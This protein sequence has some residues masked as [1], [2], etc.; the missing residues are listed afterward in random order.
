MEPAERTRS[1]Y[2]GRDYSSYYQV[3]DPVDGVIASGFQNWHYFTQYAEIK[4]WVHKVYNPVTKTWN[5]SA[6]DHKK[7]RVTTYSD[8]VSFHD[9]FGRFIHLEGRKPYQFNPDHLFSILGDVPDTTVYNISNLAWNLFHT[10]VKN[11]VSIVNFIWELKDFKELIPNLS[12]ARRNPKKFLKAAKEGGKVKAVN[13]TFLQY[14]FNWAPFIGDLQKMTQTVD[15]ISKRLDFLRKT[16]NKPVRLHYGNKDIWKNPNIGVDNRV[17]PWAHEYVGYYLNGYQA[18]YHASCI[19]IQDLDGLDDAWSNWKAGL[20]SL[21]VT[22]PLKIVWNAIPFSFLLDWVW[23]VSNWLDR[24]A[25]QPFTGRWDVMDVTYSL[26]EYAV[27]D[28]IQENYFD[29]GLNPKTKLARVNLERY[30]RRVG[31]PALLPFIDFSNLTPMEQALFG[32]LI[33][34]RHT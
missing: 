12:K 34:A 26:H 23:P 15:R 7:A 29:E 16:R 1:T 14:N 17:T 24:F 31:L 20:A 13:N 9:D 5:S 6:V 8:V 22:N 19:L 3:I 18:D 2:D 28:V 33:L 21:G 25:I 27:I 4:D 11:D 10:Q 30:R 32:S